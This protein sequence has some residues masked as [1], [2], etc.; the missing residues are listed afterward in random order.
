MKTIIITGAARG[1]GAE[2]ALRYAEQDVSLGLLD[3][4]SVELEKTAQA[5]RESGAT[6]STSCLNTCDRRKLKR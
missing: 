6:V 4:D 3:L 5:C 2:L 1:I